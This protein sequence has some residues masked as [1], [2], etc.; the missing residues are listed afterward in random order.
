V[1]V[2]AFRRSSK[3]EDSGLRSSPLIGESDRCPVLSKAL[4]LARTIDG[5][6]RNL[7][8]FFLDSDLTRLADAR[9]VALGATVEIKIVVA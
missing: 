2:R 5:A 1:R 9:V 8:R 4:E 6:E 3:D 7:A